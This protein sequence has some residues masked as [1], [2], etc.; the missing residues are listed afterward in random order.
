V[1]IR[2]RRGG[3]KIRLAG[4]QGHHD[5]RKLFQEAGIPPWVRERAPLIYLDERLAAVA[6]FWT[7]A[8]FA[9][10]GRGCRGLRIDW[11]PPAGLAFDRPLNA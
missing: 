3:E 5:L 4:R 8:E 9:V 6:C 2:Y 7:A 1:D 10:S 11:A